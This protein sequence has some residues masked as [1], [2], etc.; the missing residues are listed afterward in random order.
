MESVPLS[1]AA[2]HR[3]GGGLRWEMDVEPWLCEFWPIEELVNYNSAYEVPVDAPGYFAFATSGGGEMYALSPKG[4][5]VCPA[6]VGMSP[7]EE[8]KIASSSA[9]F[10][11]MLKNAL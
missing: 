11:G 4:E 3:T 8:L 9:E 6:F 1:I 2:F 5:V 7:K 10:E